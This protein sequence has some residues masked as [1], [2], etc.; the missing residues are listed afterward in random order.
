MLLVIPHAWKSVLPIMR[1]GRPGR[2]APIAWYTDSLRFQMNSAWYHME[3]IIVSKCGSFARI[4]LPDYVWFPWTTQELL[5]LIPFT[6]SFNMFT[7]SSLMI[8]FKYSSLNSKSLLFFG[9]GCDVLLLK[10]PIFWRSSSDI[11][12]VISKLNSVLDPIIF[13]ANSSPYFS[14]NSC[15]QR[16]IT[17]LTTTTTSKKKITEKVRRRDLTRGR[18][19][20]N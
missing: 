12:V 7:M 20:S 16:F 3:G 2:V 10:S 9:G 5:P 17:H 1:K 4:G 6:T 13:S 14:N 19:I 18:K 11:I 15:L 8:L